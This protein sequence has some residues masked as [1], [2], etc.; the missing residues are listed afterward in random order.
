MTNSHSAGTS[1]STV[2]ARTTCSGS[3]ALAISS[4]L[5]PISTEVAAA[6]ST[7][8]GLP[9]QMATS[10]WLQ[11]AQEGVEMARAHHPHRHLGGGELHQR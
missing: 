5:M 8:G 9:M 6:A 2:L 10:T 1:T 7:L 3:S 4:S 11:V